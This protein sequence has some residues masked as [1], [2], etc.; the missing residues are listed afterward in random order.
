MKYRIAEKIF[1]DDT[2]S[3]IIQEKRWYGWGVMK[4]HYTSR[5]T[6]GGTYYEN[7]FLTIEDAEIALKKQLKLNGKLKNRTITIKEY[8]EI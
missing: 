1:S 6:C 3:Y 4:G 2:H 8:E 7:G 5:M